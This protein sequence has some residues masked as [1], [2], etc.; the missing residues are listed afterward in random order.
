VVAAFEGAWR[1]FIDLIRGLDRCCALPVLWRLRAGRWVTFKLHFGVEADLPT[2]FS[3][4]LT[5]LLVHG[6]DIATAVERPWTVD[7][8]SASVAV[9]A[10]LRASAGFILPGV[11]NGPAQRAVVTFADGHAVEINV[12]GAHYSARPVARRAGAAAAD[13]FQFSPAVHG[14]IGG[15][16]EV[17]RRVAKW[18]GNI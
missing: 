8:M 3:Y 17:T 1:Q 5:D 7:P 14:R 2:A 4:G 12:G 6:Y 13:P 10:N 15:P 18:F 16:D 11:L 9:R